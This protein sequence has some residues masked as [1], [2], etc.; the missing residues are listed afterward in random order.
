MDIKAKLLKSL[1]DSIT[2]LV[3]NASFEDLIRIVA[4]IKDL[5]DG[6]SEDGDD[7]KRTALAT[8]NECK[9]EFYFDRYDYSPL[10]LFEWPI[11]KCP[12]C[13]GSVGIGGDSKPDDKFNNTVLATC[14][15]CKFEFYFDRSEYNTLQIFKCPKC[16]VSVGIDL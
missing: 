12:R 7:L 13:Q 8:C 15:K 10:Q 9:F 3:D 6:D 2:E 14:K 16:N 1:K 4:S 11:V 5:F